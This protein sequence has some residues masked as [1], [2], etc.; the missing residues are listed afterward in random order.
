VQKK[1]FL[2]PDRE[3]LSVSMRTKAIFSL[4]NQPNGKGIL[5]ISA[6]LIKQM[7]RMSKFYWLKSNAYAGERV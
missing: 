5:P 7:R 6:R 1:D 2:L 3:R 4:K